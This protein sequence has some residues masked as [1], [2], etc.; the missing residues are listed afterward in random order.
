M[1]KK[2]WRKK[3]KKNCE[4]A[5]TYQPYFDPVIDT[6]A[7]TLDIRDKTL[8][9]YYDSGGKAVISHTNKGGQT[10]AVRRP[11][12]V[13]VNELDTKALAIW[14]DL[15]LTPAGLKKLNADV[16]KEKHD[17]SFEMFLAKVL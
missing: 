16:V 12:L 9:Q 7:E 13:M 14:R 17:Q 10:N 5:G 2:A 3:I 11:Y 1:E 8:E 6:L 4:D 15:G